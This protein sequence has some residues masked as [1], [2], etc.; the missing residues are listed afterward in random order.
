MIST[1]HKMHL[2]SNLNSLSE[3][4]TQRYTATCCSIYALR[5]CV[6][7]LLSLLLEMNSKYFIYDLY[8]RIHFVSH[9]GGIVLFSD[10]TICTSCFPEGH[11]L[12][13]KL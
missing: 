10:S 4:G 12:K 6:L 13:V 8:S 1:L 7:H 5:L 9:L 3:A 11:Y 2:Y